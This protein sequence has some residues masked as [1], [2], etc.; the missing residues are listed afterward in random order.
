VAVSTGENKVGHYGEL[1]LSSQYSLISKNIQNYVSNQNQTSS[2]YKTQVVD[3]LNSIKGSIRV[4]GN[5][6]KNLK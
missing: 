6:F 2:N 5:L 3:C 1:V 4:I